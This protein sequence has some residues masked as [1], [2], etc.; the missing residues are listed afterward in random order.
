M[1]EL[2]R[3]LEAAEAEAEA[4][5]KAHKKVARARAPRPILES[6]PTQCCHLPSRPHAPAQ[7][8]KRA[9]QLET[10]LAEAADSAKVAAGAQQGRRDV[11]LTRRDGE[12]ELRTEIK[13]LKAQLERERENSQRLEAVAAEAQRLQAEAESSSAQGFVRE[14]VQAIEKRMR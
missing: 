9:A 6:T 1:A 4:E 14:R 7:A 11:H 13:T 2:A 8:E 5:R 10:E 3:Q 12:Q